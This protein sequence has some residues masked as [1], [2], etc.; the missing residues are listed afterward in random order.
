MTDYNP[1]KVVFRGLR[2]VVAAKTHISFVNPLGALYYSG[3]N[4]D[5]LVDNTTYEE[6]VHPLLTNKLPTKTELSNLKSELY[7]NDIS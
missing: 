6:V 5:D 7:S 2:G 4:I 3:Y 1:N